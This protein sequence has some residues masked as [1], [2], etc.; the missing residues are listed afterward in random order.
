M[1]LKSFLLDLLFPVECLGC[2]RESTWLC[3]TCFKKLKFGANHETLNLTTPFLDRIFIAGDYDDPLLKELIKKFKYDFLTAL[4]EPL[5]QFLIF[6]WQ[7]QISLID[8]LPDETLLMPVPLTKKRLRWRGFNQAEMLARKLS[9][10]FPYTLRQDLKRQKYSRPQ[11]G[12]SEAQRALNIKN[13]FFWQGEAL[14]GQT[15]ILLDDVV[16]TGATLNEA[17]RVLKEAGAARIYA[18]VLAKG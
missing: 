14:N 2:R 4:S 5:G 11:A 6:F 10:A 1:S 12:L 17:A 15:I 13:S 3:T 9:A 7:G 18:L 8:P 16:T